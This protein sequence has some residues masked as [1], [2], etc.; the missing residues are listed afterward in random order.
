MQSHINPLSTI[1]FIGQ[2][3]YSLFD[4]PYLKNN[5]QKKTLQIYANVTLRVSMLTTPMKDLR[6]AQVSTKLSRLLAAR[7]TYHHLFQGLETTLQ[8][9]AE[10]T[11]LDLG[12]AT[13]LLRMPA[14]ITKHATKNK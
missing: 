3:L 4:L 6:L 11:R 5:P 12:R 10:A 8:L 13:C 1:C 14:L 2:S 7:L 9:L